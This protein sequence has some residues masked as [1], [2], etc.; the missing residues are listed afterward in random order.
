MHAIEASESDLFLYL[1]DMMSS[2]DDIKDP[3][4]HLYQCIADKMSSIDTI[5]HSGRCPYPCITHSVFHRCYKSL[6]ELLFHMLSAYN[7]IRRC[8]RRH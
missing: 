4:T 3:W 2:V 1:A 8:S 5:D 7:V 6:R